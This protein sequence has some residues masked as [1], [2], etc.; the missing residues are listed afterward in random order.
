MSKFFDLFPK[1]AYDINKSQYTTYQ[2]PTNIF[3]RIGIIKETLENISSYYIYN[4]QEGDTPERL[5][6][7][8]YGTSEAHWIIM[9]ANGILDGSYDWPLNYSDF[10]N[11]ISNKYRAAAGGN[12]L[13]DIQVISWSQ[14]SANVA[15]NNIY[16]YEKVIERTDTSTKKTTEWRYQI[17]YDKK[18]IAI[19]TDRPYDYY[20]NLSP[21]GTTTNYSVDGLNIS[22][23]VYGTY[24]TIYDYEVESNEAKRIIKII[25]PEYYAQI[26][27][28]F[29]NIVNADSFIIKLTV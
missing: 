18:T 17:D 6:D 19:P 12:T 4:I 27:N 10:N 1:I 23:K 25:K 24:Q 16:K 5:A 3:M 15:A 14:Q 7:R 28:E 11:Y 22:E 26:M 8:V 13:T 9:L 20:L 29:R 21:T 2:S